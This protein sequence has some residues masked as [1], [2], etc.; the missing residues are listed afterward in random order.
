[1]I[2][3]HSTARRSAMFPAASRHWLQGRIPSS[4]SRR[5]KRRW[6][7]F[8]RPFLEGLET[9][10]LPS[11]Q[12]YGQIPLSFEA[13]YGQTDAQVQFL[14]HAPGSTFF[15]TR[16]EAVMVLSKPAATPAV[17]PGNAAALPREFAA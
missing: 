2:L 3:P 14:A 5:P 4:G 12:V 6:A 13:N 11:A 8:F 1:D 15:F 10:T 7:E 9:R 17:A 16:I